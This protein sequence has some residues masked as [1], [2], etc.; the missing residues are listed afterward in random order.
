MRK[1]RIFLGVSLLTSAFAGSLAYAQVDKNEYTIRKNIQAIPNSGD[2]EKQYDDVLVCAPGL[3]SC[4]DED[5]IAEIEKQLED[6][7]NICTA[8]YQN[9]KIAV[10]KRKEQDDAEFNKTKALPLPKTEAQ[11]EAEK[12]KANPRR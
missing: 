11:K 8:K 6:A 3:S 12:K 4:K 7:N 2:L 1:F 9:F 5:C 10:T